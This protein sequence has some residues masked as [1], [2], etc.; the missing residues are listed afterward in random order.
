MSNPVVLLVDDDPVTLQ[1]WNSILRRRQI[2]CVATS[3]ARQA[4][5]HFD[6]HPIRVL[7]TDLEMPHLDGIE[8]FRELR[9][10]S[11]LLR[12]ILCSGYLDSDNLLSVAEAGFHHIMP[13]PIARAARFS[14]E[15]MTQLA[16]AEHLRDLL[17]SLRRQ[18]LGT[19]VA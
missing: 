4:L 11:P 18:S 16:Q 14:A 6:R 3:D 5:L 15:V 8:L 17:L 19:T 2:P 7:V 1:T 12:A 13:K 10:R 9:S